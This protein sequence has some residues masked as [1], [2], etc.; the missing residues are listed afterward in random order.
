MR[1]GISCL[2]LLLCAAQFEVFVQQWCSAQIRETLTL[3]AE[4]LKAVSEDFVAEVR[5][6]HTARQFCC[7]CRSPSLKVCS[8][9][10]GKGLQGEPGRLLM[11]PTMVDLL[12][13]DMA[14]RTPANCFP[15]LLR[16]CCA[17]CMPQFNAVPFTNVYL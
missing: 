12:P 4:T 13:G 9:Q 8:E 1:R 6:Q 11:I 10:M 5:S 14:D 3:S 16:P 2:A 15:V 17:L 7:G